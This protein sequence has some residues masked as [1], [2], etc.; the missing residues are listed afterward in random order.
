M[1]QT[2]DQLIP[3]E[4]LEQS[5]RWLQQA[6]DSR[7]GEI[8]LVNLLT[9]PIINFAFIWSCFENAASVQFPDEEHDI[10]VVLKAIDCYCPAE[11]VVNQVFNVFHNRFISGELANEKFTFLWPEKREKKRRNKVIKILSDNDMSLEKRNYACG[12]ICL[13]LRN[14]LFHGVKD[15]ATLDK[16]KRLLNCAEIYLESMTDTIMANK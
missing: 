7:G 14:N 10:D 11:E 15:I 4:D 13:R 5:Q 1:A 12:L 8:S 16:Q 3:I 9:T 2:Q 6:L